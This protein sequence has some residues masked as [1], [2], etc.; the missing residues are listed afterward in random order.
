MYTL[1]TQFKN[2]KLHCIVLEPSDIIYFDLGNS[3]KEFQSI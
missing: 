3:S 1:T 2:S